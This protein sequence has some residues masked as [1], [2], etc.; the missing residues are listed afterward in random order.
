MGRPTQCLG[1]Q[2]GHPVCGSHKYGG[3]VLQLCKKVIVTK[4][5]RG[6][7]G[8]VWAVEQYDDDDDDDDDDV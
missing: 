3:L 6:G 1:V 5:Q 8:P 4:P 7:H 2:L